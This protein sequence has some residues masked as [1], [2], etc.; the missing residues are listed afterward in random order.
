M[1]IVNDRYQAALT[2]GQLSAMS[3]GDKSNFYSQLIV[4]ELRNLRNEIE[5]GE[6]GQNVEQLDQED[7]SALQCLDGGHNPDALHQGWS[8]DDADVAMDEDE[9]QESELLDELAQLQ[10]QAA[11]EA[12]MGWSMDPKTKAQLQLRAKQILT[13]LLNNEVRQLALTCVQSYITGAA[14]G[15]LVGAITAGVK[16]KLTELIMNS[17]LDILAG[18]FGKPISITP[19]EALQ[20][21]VAA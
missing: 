3:E 13:E 20:N 2:A 11:R 14:M 1:K 16:L 10:Q 9:S 12:E 17:V 15:P 6:I 4:E 18:I 5:S 21:P 7:K 8:P 19:A